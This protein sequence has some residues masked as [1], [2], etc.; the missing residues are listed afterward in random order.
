MAFGNNNGQ[1][2]SSRDANYYS[3][4]RISN[5]NDS[6]SLNFT[7]WSGL[8]KLAIVQFSQD[9]MQSSD[10]TELATI[11]L[12]PI[13]ARMFAECIEDIAKDKSDDVIYGVDTGLNEVKGVITI[14]RKRGETF[15]TIGKASDNAGYE[16]YQEFRFEKNNLYRMNMTDLKKFKYNKEYDNVVELKQLV[17]LLLDYSNAMGGGYAYAAHDIN[18]YQT[19]KSNALLASIAE[20]MGV[21]VGKGGGTA[22]NGI[23]KSFF[24]EDDSPSYSNNSNS[25][26]FKSVDDLEDELD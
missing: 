14:G 3:R 19:S 17:A 25:S 4:L 24:D 12:S 1:N 22:N 11:Y 7:Y 21:K 16:S 9:S 23:G 8:L 20:K 13:K 26:K 10:R 15:I 2:N 5:Y 18:R 6:L